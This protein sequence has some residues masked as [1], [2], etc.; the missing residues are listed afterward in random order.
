M[1]KPH[2]SPSSVDMLLKCG[3]QYRRRYIVGDIIPPGT[4][5]IRG[6]GVHAA[7]RVNFRQKLETGA[8]IALD[9]FTDAAAQGVEGAWLKGVTLDDEE[10]ESPAR[11]KAATKDIAVALARV[12]REKMT[13]RYH[14]IRVEEGVR[15]KMSE[16][17]RDL[18]GYLDL[19]A[20]D[21][22]LNG[23]VNTARPIVVD[24]KTAKRSK[25]Q[26]DVDKSFQLTTY[27]A[28]AC[29]LE[30]LEAID[31]RL[32]VAVATKTPKMQ[33][34]HSIRTKEDFRVGFDRAAAAIEAI[35]AGRFLPAPEG[36]W[37]CSPKWCGYYSTCKYVR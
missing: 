28:A 8:D 10:I 20:F 17:P 19:E 24:T 34:L 36:A 9:A 18:I 6:T 27:G 35:E 13:P 2:V 21:V 3:E 4:A 23:Q 33:T 26:D 14:P 37:W 15:L 32:E 25:T 12:A 30:G 16:F 22:D 7:L 5:M 11:A 31:V 1:K 29:T